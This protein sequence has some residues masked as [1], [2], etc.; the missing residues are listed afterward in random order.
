MV[1]NVR[2]LNSLHSTHYEE[3]LRGLKPRA[4]DLIAGQRHKGKEDRGKEMDICKY[5]TTS[6][7]SKIIELKVYV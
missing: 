6:T 7:N 1:C 4:E 5:S 2:M 3:T